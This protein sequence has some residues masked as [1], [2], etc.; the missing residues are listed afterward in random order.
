MKT[1]RGD[2][3]R[4]PDKPPRPALGAGEDLRPSPLPARRAGRSAPGAGLFRHRQPAGDGARRS[5]SGRGAARASSRSSANAFSPGPSRNGR[6]ARR[7]TRRCARC[8][9]PSRPSAPASGPWPKRSTG[10][11]APAAACSPKR[12]PASARPSAPCFPLC[13]AMPRQTAG[14]DLLPRRQ[15]PRPPPGPGGGAA[16]PRER[17]GSAAA[18]ARTG[19]PR[20]GLRA[21]GQGLPR[22]IVPAG[23]RL[24][25]PPARRPPGRRGR[26]A[27]STGRGCARWRRRTPSAPIISARNWRAGRT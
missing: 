19:R 16:A 1:Y 23:P 26:A 7:G 22:R 8:P 17:A 3:E 27:C 5:V 20:Q 9:S 21:P 6:T 15:D 2:L 25:R 11:P 18:G 13:K 12:R 4:L 24:L 10:R 14:Q